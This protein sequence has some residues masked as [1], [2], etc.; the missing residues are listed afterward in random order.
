MLSDWHLNVS[1]NDIAIKFTKYHSFLPLPV[2]ISVALLYS[3]SHIW[4]LTNCMHK[5]GNLT[6]KRTWNSTI[7]VDIIRMHGNRFL[8]DILYV[9]LKTVWQSMLD[10]KYVQMA[11]VEESDILANCMALSLREKNKVSIRKHRI[12]IHNLINLLVDFCLYR[13]WQKQLYLDIF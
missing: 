5:W 13:E 2:A 12:W 10:K 11:M 3:H 9:R 8:Y 7:S 4:K 1:L 6:L